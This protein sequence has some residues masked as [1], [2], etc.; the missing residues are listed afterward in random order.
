[1]TIEGPQIRILGAG[2]EVALEAYLLPRIETSVFLLG[3]MR[4]A[5][6]VD[7]GQYLQ[8]TYAAAVQGDTVLGVVG[9]FWNG[10]L[11]LQAPLD[12][13]PELI[14]TALWASSR[15][16][17]GFLG[18]QAQ[19]RSALAHL[20]VSPAQ[21]QVDDPQTLYGLAL[22]DLVVPPLLQQP[23]VRARRIEARDLEL[24]VAWRVAY[25]MEAFQELENTEL[26][27]ACRRQVQ[28][29]LA[30]RRAWILEVEDRPVSTSGFNAMLPELVQVG[31][32][33]TPPELRS[34]H[35]AKAVVAAS[36]L[37]A[38]IT[39]VAKAILFTGED[40]LPAARAYMALGFR[41]IADYHILL[42]RQPLTLNAG[43][44]AGGRNGHL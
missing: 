32:V 28:R 36:L 3:N 1:V 44:G 15:P 18:P 12:L 7:R 37:Q 41:A 14:R 27:S 42:L 22:A 8:G 4:K 26:W 23:G 17:L 9:H 5:G 2:D 33:Y 20:A 11:L 30:E 16:L 10:N 39:G 6:L 40:N 31:G 21:V 43:Q 24:L 35:Y 29:S 25:H 13:L 38:Q 19:V 34:R